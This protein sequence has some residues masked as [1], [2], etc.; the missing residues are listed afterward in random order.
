M[1]GVLFGEYC[2]LVQLG[3]FPWESGEMGGDSGDSLESGERGDQS[4]NIV[5]RCESGKRVWVEFSDD[6]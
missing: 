1:F 5:W 3:N 4:G 2:D 6:F